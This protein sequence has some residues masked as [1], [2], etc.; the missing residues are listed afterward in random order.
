MYSQR[1]KKLGPREEHRQQEGQRINNSV[2]LSEKF[3]DLKSLMAELEYC[4]AG[5]TAKKGE[6][7]HTFNVQNARSVLAFNCPNE[8][9]VGG[10]FD[11]SAE[12]A[13]AVAEHRTSVLGQA[14]CQ[15]WLSKTTIDRIRCHNV[16]HYKLTLSY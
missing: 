10:D 14:C 5:S 4:D 12:L 7:K 9:C 13:R 3:R 1:Y 2:S 11:L 8:E 6:I 15:G 16:L